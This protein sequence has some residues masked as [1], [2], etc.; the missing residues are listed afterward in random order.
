MLCSVSNRGSAKYSPL[1]TILIICHAS[2]LFCVG[3]DDNAVPYIP[4]AGN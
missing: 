3:I 2:V 1:E 4:Q